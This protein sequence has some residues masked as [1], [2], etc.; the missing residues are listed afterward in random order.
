[1]E[2]SKVK[3]K[4]EF[5]NLIQL[6]EHFS[7]ETVCR[8]YL[9]KLRWPDGQTQCP[10]C[11]NHKVYRFSDGKRFK[12]AGCRKQFTAKV[13]TIFEGSKVPLRKWFVAI[14]VI[15]SHKKGISSHQLAK[16]IGVTQ[17]T[18]W[19]IL[20]RVR[21]MLTEKNPTLLSGTVQVDETYVGGKEKNK[22]Q[23]K[24]TAHAQGRSIKAKTPVLGIVQTDGKLIAKAVK[25]TKSRTIIPEMQAV[26]AYGTTIY[27][28][29]YR[30]Y[31][32]L[33]RIYDHQYVKHSQ[34]EYVNGIVHTNQIEGFWSLLKRGIVG[35]Y[36][37]V[38]PKHLDRYVTEFAYRYNSRDNQEVERLENVI[39]KSE[40][41]RLKYV[42]L[43]GN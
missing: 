19:F 6:I 43:T 3:S 25:D 20:H 40:G 35:V 16:D 37:H 38:S 24:R 7:D 14:Y 33:A 9:E 5:S 42:Q 8:E 39:E 10:H 22:H 1:M 12:C 23:N 32:P 34:G 30:A 18:A 13:G 28:D 29:E 4:S 31:K 11:Q 2:T 41:K 36:H 21:E 17:K 27:T 26:V 15:T